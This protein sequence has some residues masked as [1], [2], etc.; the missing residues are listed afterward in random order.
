V[1]IA[2]IGLPTAS[3]RHRQVPLAKPRGIYEVEGKAFLGDGNKIVELGGS[4]LFSEPR[5]QETSLLRTAVRRGSTPSLRPRVSGGRTRPVSDGGQAAP[6]AADR[7]NRPALARLPPRSL[8]DLWCT[9]LWL[10][11][12]RAGM[13]FSPA[14][15]R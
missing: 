5:S 12:R 15:L 4:I 9:S 1:S 11:R 7:P 6:R 3:P 14:R 2:P 13:L 8:A 10:K